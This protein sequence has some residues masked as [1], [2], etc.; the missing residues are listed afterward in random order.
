MP[1]FRGEKE[2]ARHKSVSRNYGMLHVHGLVRLFFP[3]TFF[4][5]AWVPDRVSF[6]FTALPRVRRTSDSSSI[7]ET[8]GLGQDVA[9]MLCA[10]RAPCGQKP[11]GCFR[12]LRRVI[13]F[14]WC[15]SWACFNC[16]RQGLGRGFPFWGFFLRWRGR[17]SLARESDP[18]L[19][20]C[21]SCSFFF[22]FFVAT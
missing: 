4:A 14:V 3:P 13:G 7:A 10:K 20:R 11:F 19:F 21:F 5:H 15:S 8:S 6:N 18:P 12:S 17:G 1:G 2:F 9:L 22:F 16:T